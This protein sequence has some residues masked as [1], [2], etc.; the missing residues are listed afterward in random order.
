MHLIL[1]PSFLLYDNP[2]PDQ[3]AAWLSPRGK[4]VRENKCDTEEKG[5]TVHRLIIQNTLLQRQSK[6]LSF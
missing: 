6:P 4:M 2:S 3:W 1:L 5:I